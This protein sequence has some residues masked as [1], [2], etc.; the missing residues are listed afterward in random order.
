MVV[1]HKLLAMLLSTT[2]IRVV[3]NFETWLHNTPSNFSIRP[4]WTRMPSTT[5]PPF[6]DDIPTHALLVVDYALI[7]SGDKSE[8]DK[9]WEAATKLGFW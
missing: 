9:L 3:A 5:L 7:K 6:P 4:T 8:I 1:T 2:W